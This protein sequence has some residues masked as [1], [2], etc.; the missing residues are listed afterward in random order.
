ITMRAASSSASTLQR[1]WRWRTRATG[2]ASPLCW[3][4]RP[5]EP[6]TLG[7][8][9]CCSALIRPISWRIRSPLRSMCRCDAPDRDALQ[10]MIVDE[11]TM[12]RIEQRSREQCVPVIQRLQHQGAEAIVVACT[13]LPL[14]VRQED[15]PLL[16]LD[17]TAL[18]AE[19]ALRPAFP[20]G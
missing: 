13:E 2:M 9:W 11:L 18:H 5:G 14:L 1:R 12:G 16:L 7:R 15:S 4:M 19:A 8:T 3:S 6:G 17:T 20:A 10:R